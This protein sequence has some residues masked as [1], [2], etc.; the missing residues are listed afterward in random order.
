MKKTRLGRRYRGIELRSTARALVV[1]ALLAGVS[2]AGVTPYVSTGLAG[3]ASAAS[4][5]QV[6]DFEDDSL[7]NPVSSEWSDWE[8][9]GDNPSGTT[10]STGNL[11]GAHEAKVSADAVSGSN[12]PSRITTGRSSPAQIEEVYYKIRVDNWEDPDQDATFWLQNESGTAFFDMNFRGDGTLDISNNTNVGSFTYSIDQTM[13]VR[14]ELDYGDETA[15]VYINETYIG[16]GDFINSANEGVQ[17]ITAGVHNH[18]TTDTATVWFDDIRTRGR[19]GAQSSPSDTYD[20]T[21]V[22]DDQSGRF[23]PD[24]ST[25]TVSEWDPGAKSIADPSESDEWSEIATKSFNANNETRWTLT[26][27]DYYKLTVTGPTGDTWELI[28]IQANE[29]RDRDRLVILPIQQGTPTPTPT[30]TRTPGVTP[31][32]T[33]TPSP[34]P[35][36]TP[37]PTPTPATGFGPTAFGYCDVPGVDEHGLEVEYFDPDDTTVAFNYH[38]TG[39]DNETVYSGTKTFDEPIGYYRG[40]IAPATLNNT[41]PDDTDGTY[42]GTRDDGSTFNGSLSWP[43][44]SFGGPVGGGG[45]STTSTATTYGGWLLLLGGGYLA[46][47]RFGDGQLGAA[48]GQ[49]GQQLSRRLGR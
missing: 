23:P 20:Q 13:D 33:P 18:H 45:S 26:D 41:D 28:G 11:E 49:A 24:R 47:R 4:W 25:L 3:N 17:N 1:V 34:T 2:I 6:D 14:V 8:N 37:F 36:A 21:Y 35:G 40:C 27:G 22:L 7:E 48:L 19:W 46:Y 42:N 43:E 12:T 44:P 31:F 39:P 15:D 5:T 9:T 10:S 30:A 38:L 16:Q 29:S 32:P